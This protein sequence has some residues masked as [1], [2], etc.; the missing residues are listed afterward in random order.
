MTNFRT[1]TRET[2]ENELCTLVVFIL[3]LCSYSFT[4][5]KKVIT[6]R[7]P[8]RTVTIDE[9]ANDKRRIQTYNALLSTPLSSC[10][11]LY[12]VELILLILQKDGPDGLIDSIAREEN[13]Y[14]VEDHLIPGILAYVSEDEFRNKRL[15]DFGCG[16]GASTMIL[17]RKF[18]QTEIV[19]V[20]L[21]RDEIRIAEARAKYYNFED[22]VTFLVSPDSTTLPEKIGKFDFIVLYAVYEHMLPN[23][24][25]K[26][27]Q[28]LWK[29]LEPGGLLF[30]NET[31]YRF[32]PIEFHTTGLPLINYLPDRM[33]FAIARR[34]SKRVWLDMPWAHLLR[35]GIRG[36]TENE[37]LR[38]IRKSCGK[39][40]LL[41]PTRLGCKDRIDLWYVPAEPGSLVKGGPIDFQHARR[42]Y[43]SRLLRYILKLFLKTTGV[44]FLQSM[45]LAI[46]KE[47]M[48]PH[49]K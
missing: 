9:M 8:Q 24:R 27:L 18:P 34:Y 39:P 44:A 14:Y 45:T 1:T 47:S 48:R 43:K 28:H 31:P 16:S 5:E 2:L 22:R 20:D 21:M 12:P 7:Y 10:E 19:G 26:L 42:I 6:L 25:K 49:Q 41:V 15:L 17:S 30:I 11:T 33:A 23:E 29:V 37:I 36:A 32:Y 38:T 13:H 46:Q 35:H 3:N 4:S 40:V